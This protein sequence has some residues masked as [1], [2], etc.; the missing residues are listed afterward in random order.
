M[1][2]LEAGEKGARGQPRSQGLAR[3]LTVTRFFQV[4]Q[5]QTTAA[6]CRI[7]PTLDQNV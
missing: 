4:V 3:G 6:Y 7:L 1:D 5:T 2:R